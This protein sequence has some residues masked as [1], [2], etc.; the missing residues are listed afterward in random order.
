MAESNKATFKT[1]LVQKL[2]DAATDEGGEK[3]V[4]MNQNAKL[5][6]GELLRLFVIEAFDRSRLEA[7]TA[8]DEEIGIEHVE[9]VLPHLLLDF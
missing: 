4:Q 6:A 5:L 7:D 2:C 1:I 3:S 9:R 8:G